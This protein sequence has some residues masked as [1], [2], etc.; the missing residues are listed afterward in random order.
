MLSLC[1]RFCIERSFFDYRNRA[2]GSV[3][4]DVFE[5]VSYLSSF[6]GYVRGEWKLLYHYCHKNCVAW[7][8]WGEPN[9]RCS[10]SLSLC[11][12][13]TTLLMSM[14]WEGRLHHLADNP[15]IAI[16]SR[17]MDSHTHFNCNLKLT[18]IVIEN[19]WGLRCPINHRIDYEGWAVWRKWDI[20]RDL[21]EEKR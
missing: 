17:V 7:L 8:D 6:S 15:Q 14:S 13:E 2:P 1:N 16:K 9:C 18:Q 12:A 3:L 11:L 21:I 5:S 19:S 4:V 20:Y 10:L